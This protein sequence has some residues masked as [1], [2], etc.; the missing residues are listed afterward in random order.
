MLAELRRRARA[1]KRDTLALYLV[2]RHP[3]TPWYAKALALLIAGYALSPIDLIPDFIPVLGY[4]DDV[5]LLPAAIV[6]CVRLIPTNVLAACRAEAERRFAAGRP[7]SRKA[8]A[9]IVALWL[10]LFGA[11]LAWLWQSLPAR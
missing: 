7:V 9:I 10:A 6:L 4:L 1:I 8:G 5:I 2:A 11:A 3:E